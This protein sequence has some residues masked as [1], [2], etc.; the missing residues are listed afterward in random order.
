ML[1]FVGGGDCPVQYEV[2]YQGDEYYIRYRHSWLTIDKNDVDVFEQQ[3]AHE[4]ADDGFWSA[5]DTQTYLHLISKAI[6]EDKLEE[7]V[8]PSTYQIHK[9]VQNSS[10]PYH[11]FYLEKRL[12]QLKRLGP[13]YPLWSFAVTGLLGGPLGIGYLLHQNYQSFKRQKAAKRSWAIS[14]IA[15]VLLTGL[16]T[17]LASSAGSVVWLYLQL[18]FML[19]GI[20][21]FYSL[22]GK[23]IKQ[24]TAYGGPVYKPTHVILIG[25]V[26]FTFTAVATILVILVYDNLMS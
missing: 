2:N 9:N 26:F 24:Y 6:I 13:I 25:F 14:L 20:I 10:D 8:L 17:W 12:N 5:A 22:Q 11:D 3:L 23:A 7:L 21:L 19:T 4:S 16:A 1:P 18:G 15:F